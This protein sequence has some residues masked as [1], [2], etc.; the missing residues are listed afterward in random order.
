MRCS[1]G[2]RKS[3]LTCDSKRKEYLAVEISW[4][5]DTYDVERAHQ[6]AELLRRLGYPVRTAVG[7]TNILDDAKLRTSALGVLVAL[8]D[9]EDE[10]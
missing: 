5:I 8:N 9:D 6:R 4:V 1:L 3:E 10:I 7:G 2:S